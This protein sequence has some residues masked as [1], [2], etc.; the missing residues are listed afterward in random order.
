MGDRALRNR[1]AEI[2]DSVERRSRVGLVQSGLGALGDAVE[3]RVVA[4]EQLDEDGFL[5]IE[6]VIEA[7]R[8]DS[9]GVGDFLQRGAQ[10][11]GR[12]QQCRRLQDFGA[13]CAVVK[14]VALGEGRGGPLSSARLGPHPRTLHNTSKLTLSSRAWP[15]TERM[16]G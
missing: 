12:D 6:M 5:R 7:S 1:R 13:P 2:D 14:C 11:R 10:A 9:S 3:V 4:A 16:F 8:K 15:P